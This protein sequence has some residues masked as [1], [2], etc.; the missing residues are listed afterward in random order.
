MDVQIWVYRIVCIAPFCPWRQKGAQRAPLKES[1]HG[2]FLK[3]PIPLSA[4]HF[5][6][7]EMAN[8]LSS[9]SLPWSRTVVRVTTARLAARLGGKVDCFSERFTSAFCPLARERRLPSHRQRVTRSPFRAAET[10][11]NATLRRAHLGLSLVGR[12]KSVSA[13][14]CGALFESPAVYILCQTDPY[15]E[16]R[17]P[18]G[19][20]PFGGVLLVLFCHC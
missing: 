10:V 14:S 9:R 18:E 2:T 15:R 7:G 16:N 17:C 5:A 12:E 8:A 3:D 4:R 11:V 19:A 20:Q 1:T 13:S 6:Y